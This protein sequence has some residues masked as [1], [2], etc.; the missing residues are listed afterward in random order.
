MV[1]EKYLT[2]HLSQAYTDKRSFPSCVVPEK[3]LTKKKKINNEGDI[4][5]ETN[6]DETNKP[7]KPN[8]SHIMV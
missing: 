3:S 2:E 6:K 1:F 5:R 4:C 8:A 7:R